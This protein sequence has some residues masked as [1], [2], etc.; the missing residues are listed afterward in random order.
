MWLHLGED[1]FAIVKDEL[2]GDR[3]GGG[4]VDGYEVDGALI[5]FARS[6]TPAD[7]V[8]LSGIKA[9]VVQTGLEQ[10]PASCFGWAYYEYDL[11]NEG[12]ESGV[13]PPSYGVLLPK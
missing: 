6:L 13:C 10:T 11:K 9:D 3:C 8:E 2:G 7:I 4:I 1:R 12:F 5:R